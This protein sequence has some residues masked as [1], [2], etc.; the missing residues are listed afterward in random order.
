MKPVST[1]DFRP[2]GILFLSV[3]DR[4]LLVAIASGGHGNSGTCS[5]MTC[6]SIGAMPLTGFLMRSWLAYLW[7]QLHELAQLPSFH[8]PMASGPLGFP[9]MLPL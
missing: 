2:M 1:L 5:A 7:V 6:H 3:Q 9:A 8:A 4:F